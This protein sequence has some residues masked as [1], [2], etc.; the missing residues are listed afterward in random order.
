[1]DSITGLGW[2]L[3]GVLPLIF[4]IGLAFLVFRLRSRFRSRFAQK[5]SEG[6]GVELTAMGKLGNFT[7]A[8]NLSSG[9]DTIAKI[10]TNAPAP[11]SL[12]TTILKPTMGARSLSLVLSVV[13]FVL[14]WTP[15]GNAYLP[16]GELL[17]III[18]AGVLYA[19]MNMI[20]YQASYD[21]QVLNIPNWAFQ[22]REFNWKD[23][24]S[25]K[26]NGHYLYV[27]RFSDG[28][29][30]ELHKYLVG[31]PEFLSY[32]NDRIAENTKE[33]CLSYPR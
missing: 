26:D 32:A 17:R 10:G 2:L 15:L 19:A 7:G 9:A 3:F 29:K 4:W 18:S 21:R 12:N 13:M 8:G 1:M 14:L 23:L 20:V 28:R 25:I 22:Q 6:R 16:Q 30:A 27:L 31:I 11:T 24:V 33:E 5:D